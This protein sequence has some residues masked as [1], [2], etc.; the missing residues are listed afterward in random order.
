MQMITLTKS[1]FNHSFVFVLITKI[2][3]TN[4]YQYIN[5][6]NIFFF[7]LHK[8]DHVN[9][10]VLLIKLNSLHIKNDFIFIHFYIIFI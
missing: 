3:K 4:N 8:I 7:F 9:D 6:V 5:I 1:N 10:E 2:F